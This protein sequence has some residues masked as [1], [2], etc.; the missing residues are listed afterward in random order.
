MSLEKNMSVGDR[1]SGRSVKCT[2]QTA[3]LC[4]CLVI[5][6]SAVP[7]YHLMDRIWRS[8]PPEPPSPSR[9]P[10][11]AARRRFSVTVLQRETTGDLRLQGLCVSLEDGSLCEAFDRFRL[12]NS[13][14]HANMPHKQTEWRMCAL[15]VGHCPFGVGRRS[16]WDR[17][18]QNMT[19]VNL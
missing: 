19:G 6:L 4:C 1:N 9:S 7:G 2:H 13:T 15:G 11:V 3:T 5:I 10:F 12:L 16:H 17:K 14:T 18:E 8:Q